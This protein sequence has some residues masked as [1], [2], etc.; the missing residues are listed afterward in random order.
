MTAAVKKTGLG[1]TNLRIII[2]ENT[3]IFEL[4]YFKKT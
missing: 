2:F 3:K 4:Y 1:L